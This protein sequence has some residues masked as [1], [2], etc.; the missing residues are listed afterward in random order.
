MKNKFPE[1]VYK[2]LYDNLNDMY[3]WEIEDYAT[4]DFAQGEI[5]NKYE[6]V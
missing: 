5:S 4:E 2:L 1:P 3:V 6:K